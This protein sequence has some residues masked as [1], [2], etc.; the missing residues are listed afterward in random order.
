[1]LCSS[2]FCP[3]YPISQVEKCPQAKRAATYHAGEMLNSA[4]ECADRARI[5]LNDLD[6]NIHANNEV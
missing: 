4:A 1:M 6:L 2:H 5:A 3:F